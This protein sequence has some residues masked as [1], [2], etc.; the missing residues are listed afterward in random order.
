VQHILDDARSGSDRSLGVEVL[1]DIHVPVLI[2]W[3]AEGFGCC[4][5]ASV[6]DF[7]RIEGARVVT[8]PGCGHIP[9]LEKP[10]VTRRAVADFVKTLK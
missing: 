4:R 3:G 5:C 7:A 9:Q 10:A 1:T 2:L 6:E 8:L